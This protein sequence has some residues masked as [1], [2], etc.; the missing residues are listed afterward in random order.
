MSEEKLPEIAEC[1]WCG[2]PAILAETRFH[3]KISC[4]RT[5]D[6]AAVARGVA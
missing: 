2:S 1:P 3:W 4:R 6:C 5:F